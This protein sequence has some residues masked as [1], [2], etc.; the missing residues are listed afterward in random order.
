MASAARKA[1][2]TLFDDA[3]K[4]KSAMK[5]LLNPAMEDAGSRVFPA[6]TA[7]HDQRYGIR[8]DKG[9]PVKDKPNIIRLHLQIN[10]NA[11]S[12]TLRDLVKEDSHKVFSVADV[13]TT[14]E[15]TEENLNKVKEQFLRNVKV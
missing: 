8:I 1:I 6:R 3:A 7:K 11:K 5:R 10:S 2:Q 14:Q 13:D 12:K 9:E 15:V 4:N